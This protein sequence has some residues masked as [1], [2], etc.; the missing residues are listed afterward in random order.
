MGRILLYHLSDIH[1]GSHHLGTE[2]NIHAGRDG[3]HF[4]TARALQDSVM[5]QK[6]S[7]RDFGITADDRTAMVVGGD[8]TRIGS[9]YDFHLTHTFLKAKIAWHK[10]RSG[11]VDE[12]GL[13]WPE[14]L[15]TVPGNHDHWQGFR[16][17]LKM[18]WKRPSSWR[19]I[20]IPQGLAALTRPPAFNP[21]LT[22]DY[23]EPTPWHHT[24]TARDGT[25]AV[26]LFGVDS[27]SGLQGHPTN[28]RAVGE[29]SD[30]Q[31]YGV[32]AGNA[33]KGLQ[34]FLDEAHQ[35]ATVPSVAAIVC[36]HAF[37]NNGGLTDAR[38]L[39]N[40]SRVSLLA[41]ARQ[42]RVR[43]VLTGHVHYFLEYKWN[44]VAPRV[45]EI[46]CGTT[47]QL[48]SPK[49]KFR[50]GYYVHVFSLDPG[51]TG[52]DSLNWRAWQYRS[53]NGGTFIRNAN[54]KPVD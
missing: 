33:K 29:I 18:L 48:G 13:A 14:A 27:N 44:A 49:Q 51:K 21:N 25:F 43:A 39:S 38:P 53:Q 37:A 41:L 17:D 7:R 10:D 36:H 9:D 22:P 3:H 40:A 52:W 34:Q 54:F 50:P 47:L 23:F 46:R 8:L 19:K 45:W 32:A 30:E 26:E 35:K 20:V 31:L 12:L 1:I 42:Y 16:P 2:S 15:F 5:G 24:I 11:A 28:F 6:F 4:Q